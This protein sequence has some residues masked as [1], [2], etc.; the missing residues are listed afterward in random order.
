M[1]TDPVAC[2]CG[3]SEVVEAFRALQWCR[4]QHIAAPCAYRDTDDS[5]VRVQLH[6]HYFSSTWWR[7]LEVRSTLLIKHAPDGR[8]C[9]LEER[10]NDAPLLH[11]R[12]FS[13]ARRINGMAS[14]L[15]TP[16]LLR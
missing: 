8:V 1:F 16:L 15:L 12:P 3:C 10:W 13:W 6:Q 4:P 5:A 7:G 11:W 2:C 9:E 14:G